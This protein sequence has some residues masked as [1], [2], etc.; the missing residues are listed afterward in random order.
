MAAA[1]KSAKDL[2]GGLNMNVVL[3]LGWVVAVVAMLAAYYFI[4]YEPLSEEFTREEATKTRLVAERQTAENNLRRYNSDV[5]ELARAR[6]RAQALQSVLPND[7]DIPGFMR[8]VNALAEASGLTLA[9]IQPVD[10][11][12]EQY[13]ARIP[14]QLRARGTYLSL[15]RFFHS[16]SQL[17]RVINMENIK[18]TEAKVDPVSREL[19]VEAA[20]LATTFRSVPRP[21]TPPGRTGP[22]GRPAPGARPGAAAAAAGGGAP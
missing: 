10:E 3:V 7:P 20:M 19:R 11:R 4:F 9:L 1:K 12:V 2:L 18:L 5:A 17:P 22:G 13:Y 14:V 21:T 6:Q 8:N 15:A 16:V